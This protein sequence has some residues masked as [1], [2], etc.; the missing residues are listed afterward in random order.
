MRTTACV[1]ALLGATFFI[2]GC[3]DTSL[4]PGAVDA[5]AVATAPDA[6]GPDAE[7]GGDDR[8]LVTFTESGDDI[9]NPERGFYVGFDLLSPPAPHSM[10][11]GGHTIALA[12]VRLDDYRDRSLD[13]EL[14]DG[15]A[16]GFDAVRAA[17][18]KVAVRFTYNS[19]QTEDAPKARILEHIGQLGPVFAANADVIAIVQAGFIGAWGEWHG[20][21]NGLDNDAD[22]TEILQAL[23]AAVPASRSV[24]V[25]TPMFKEAAFPGVELTGDEPW[26][27][28]QMRVGHHNDCFLAS[29]SD[30]GTYA[31][32]VSEWMDYVAADTRFTAMGGETCALNPPRTDCET[33]LDEM[34][35]HHW[36]YLNEQ[37]NQAVI[38]A[39]VEQGCEGEIRQRLGYRFA[40]VR[41]AHTATVAPGGVLELEVDLENRGFAAPFNARPVHV[42][43]SDETTRMVARLSGEDARRWAP[44]QTVTVGARLRVPA[45][46]TEGSYSISVWLPDDDATLATDPRYAVR[47]ANDGTWDGDHGDNVLTRE[48]VIDPTA[49]G[50]VDP[51]A[52]ELTVLP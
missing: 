4:E 46:T 13:G 6:S 14:L 22:R 1:R 20:S 21:T 32:P 40:L 34:A 42:V 45:T 29:D 47:F 43:V 3:S 12:I 11:A 38:G 10:R 49:P 7:T 25:R 5:G 37:Y 16:D 26:G 27:S 35:D 33:A 31:S 36:S 41:A 24:Q 48:L 39:W 51:T 15:L 19:S 8:V 44:G 23:L 28:A 30:Y 50:D 18:V 52:T 17:G 2:L 9:L